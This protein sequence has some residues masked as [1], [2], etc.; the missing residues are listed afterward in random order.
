MI[1]RVPAVKAFL[2]HLTVHRSKST[3]FLPR[4][5]TL[6]NGHLFLMH[7][8]FCC[9]PFDSKAQT[10]LKYP[11][12]DIQVKP[13][14]SNI[15]L[16][17]SYLP[18]IWHYIFSNFPL[19]CEL[20]KIPEMYPVL[21][22]SYP[23]FPLNSLLSHYRRVMVITYYLYACFFILVPISSSISSNSLLV[24]YIF[25]TKPLI[26]FSTSLDKSSSNSILRFALILP[27]TVLLWSIL[28]FYVFG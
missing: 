24:L 3:V 8:L 2:K 27:K 26:I 7:W 6:K 14:R 9:F 15:P 5:F 28:I 19:S 12:Q 23:S 25:D 17:L 16:S 13:C 11:T 22:L 18:S 10:P 1:K 4:L 20:H 21:L